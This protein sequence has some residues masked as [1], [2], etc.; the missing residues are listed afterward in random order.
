MQVTSKFTIAMHII[1]CIYHYAPKQK[2]TSV[3]LSDS[4]GAD[5]TIIRRLLGQLQSAG[6]LYV[7]PGVG[8]ASLTMT[9][10]KITML[11]VYRAIEAS[12]NNMFRFYENPESKCPIAQNIHAVLD[13]CW[14]YRKQCTIK[15]RLSI[16]KCYM[17]NCF[18]CWMR[19][20]HIHLWHVLEIL[21][22]CSGKSN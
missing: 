8:G 2:V 14:K 11:N 18:R 4:T 12:D 20:K 16:C 21:I 5:A 9:L 17:M 6:M 22:G 1:L 19:T 7:K 15:C 3:F 13:I 10:E